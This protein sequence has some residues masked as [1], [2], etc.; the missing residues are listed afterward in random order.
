M[1]T[2]SADEWKGVAEVSK[3]GVRRGQGNSKAKYGA[4]LWQFEEAGEDR[5]RYNKWVVYLNHYLIV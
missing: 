2:L 1:M 3:F 5:N 4:A